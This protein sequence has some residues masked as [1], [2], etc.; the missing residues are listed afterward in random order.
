[1]N[2]E[3]YPVRKCG[4]CSRPE[5]RVVGVIAHLYGGNPVGQ[6]Y[7]HTCFSCGAKFRTQ[8]PRRLLGE[9]STWVVFT[10]IGLGMIGFGVFYLFDVVRCFSNGDAY[11]SLSMILVPL[12][13]FGLGGALTRFAFQALR[14]AFEP[15]RAHFQNPTL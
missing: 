8:S 3:D 7:D 12:L 1:M 13:S 6:T 14:E 9:L 4:K 10:L 11:F 2:I 5:A 15:V